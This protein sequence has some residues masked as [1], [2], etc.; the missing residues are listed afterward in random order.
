MNN[1][2]GLEIFF[3]FT[4]FLLA[5]SYAGYPLVLLALK[6]LK[7]KR[8]VPPTEP[9]VYPV[10]VIFSAYNEENIIK[11][12][13]NNFLQLDYP[14][15]KLELI[16]VS[17]GSTDKTNEIIL[18]YKRENIKAIIHP[19]RHGKTPAL[20]RAVREARGEILIFTDADTIFPPDTIKKFVT[21]FAKKEVGLVTGTTRCWT[22]TGADAT[23][24]NAYLRYEDLLKGLESQVGGVVGASG[25]NYAL[26]KDLYREL[27]PEI[28]ND[29][30]HPIEV[31]LQGKRAVFDSDIVCY[32]EAAVGTRHEYSRQVRMVG[33]AFLI[34]RRYI[35]QLLWQGKFLYA[36]FLTSHKFLRW[37]TL[38]LM[39][40]VFV[41]NLLLWGRGGIYHIT[42]ML[43][44]AFY[45]VVLLGP[46][47][48]SIG[49]DYRI[50]SLP[51]DFCFMS[52]AG[53]V[54]L[55]RSLLA[56]A[57]IVWEKQR[58]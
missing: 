9:I 3:F 5:Y 29:F 4:A 21:H 26:R 12:K 24:N 32:E 47:L 53:I 17:D 23:T 20:N 2:T 58:L 27:L 15:D 25:A 6:L 31:V 45:F 8:Q 28:V 42:G 38:P 46:I 7:P 19:K 33:Q 18:S 34:Y 43:Q 11:E 55:Y 51:F 48:R 10:S 50:F 1:I 16:I 37:L 13:I 36:F 52:L 49:L 40:A 56:G 41:S 14:K 57:S 22:R 35:L 30:V 54:G 44:L 39:G